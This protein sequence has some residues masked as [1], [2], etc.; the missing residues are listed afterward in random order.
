MCFCHVCAALKIILWI[1]ENR[2]TKE[3]LWSAL[4][5][6]RVIC[7]VKNYE[8]WLGKTSMFVV[9]ANTVDGVTF[10][11]LEV[12]K[13][14]SYFKNEIQINDLPKK[15]VSHALQVLTVFNP[16]SHRSLLLPPK[17]QN[18]FLN[19]NFISPLYF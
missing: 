9:D 18:K 5:P 19:A 1:F 3:F 7:L 15:I 17:Q 14:S 12:E 2:L 4:R 8:I 16:E 6:L 13:K 11:K 10:K